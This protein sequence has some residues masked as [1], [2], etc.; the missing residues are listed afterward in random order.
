MRLRL[1]ANGVLTSA[2][3]VCLLL[4]LVLV[5]AP[6]VLGQDPSVFNV[7]NRLAAPSWSHPLGTDELGRDLLLRLLE[8]GRVSLAVGL[9]AALAS[10]V[11]G[12]A[13]GLT[14]GYHGGRLDA[15]LMRVTDGVI[16]HLG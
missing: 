6:G 8:G 9:T 13:V 15:L 3:L 16:A 14:A 4:L 1:S 12:T 10:A 11:L 7:A 5:V 2:A